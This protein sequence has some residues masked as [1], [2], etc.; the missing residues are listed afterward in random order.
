MRLILLCIVGCALL[1]PLAASAELRGVDLY[2]RGQYARARK[3]LE[4]ELRS[5]KLSKEQRSKARLYLAASLYASGAEESARIQLEELALTDPTV[6][7]D[8]VIFPE[9]F[10]ALAEASFKRM[11]AKG[12]QAPPAPAGGRP[13]PAP[14]SGEDDFQRHLTASVRLYESLEY[15]R[16]LQQLQRARELS[17]NAEQDVIV[18]LYEGLILADMGQGEQ[19][20][21]AFKTALLLNPEAKLPVKASP[22][23]SSD[24]EA[25]RARVRQELE[26]E[27]QQAAA[28][29]AKSPPPADPEKPAQPP[30]PQQAPQPEE[31]RAASTVQLRPAL[32]GFMDPVGKA[33]G[34]GGGLTL[35]LGSLDLGARVLMGK[36]VG[37]GV[38]AGLV[39]GSG[40]LRPRLGLRG[41][42]I[43]GAK[44]YGGG[45]VA[46]LRIHP[47][48]RLSF[49]VD[50]GAE[51]FSAPAQYRALALTGSAGV[52]FDLL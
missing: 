48:S 46:G 25:M 47:A 45:A 51:Y 16:A 42:A 1:W 10:V 38:E 37:V 36:Q 44:A 50:V 49:L 5:K 13:V 33:V 43:P 39:L 28:H 22:K 19:A 12:A 41:T 15:E 14:V 6:K 32:F 17:R 7:V 52:G 4:K 34:A 29:P 18:S 30:P 3:S 8:P 21:A 24:F 35:G 20:L 2:E 23:V 27:R 31:E 9:G 40:A 26:R 11:A